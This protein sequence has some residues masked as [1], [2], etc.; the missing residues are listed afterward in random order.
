M[1]SAF[2]NVRDCNRLPAIAAAMRLWDGVGR[3]DDLDGRLINYF[4][5]KRCAPGKSKKRDGPQRWRSWSIVYVAELIHKQGVALRN[6]STD[7]F[8]F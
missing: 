1:E 7:F 3:H 8:E 5:R 6:V 4:K 2:K